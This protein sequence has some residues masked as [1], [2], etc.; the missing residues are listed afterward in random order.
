LFIKVTILNEIYYRRIRS[1]YSNGA[2]IKFSQPS[3]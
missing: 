2:A 3:S 1:V